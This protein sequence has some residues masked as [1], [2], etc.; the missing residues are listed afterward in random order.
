MTPGWSLP[1]DPS[2]F[3]V[4]IR[5]GAQIEADDGNVRF[6]VDKLVLDTGA[7]FDL[8]APP[9]VWTEHNLKPLGKT[10]METLGKHV[11]CNHAD[12]TLKL[13]PW[14]ARAQ[15]VTPGNARDWLIGYPLLRWFDLLI[16]TV[17]FRQPCLIGPERTLLRDG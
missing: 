17:P 16:R 7:A 12:V 5:T 13:G 6:E 15:L 14:Y 11:Y 10:R 1:L 4:A 3:E 8:I 2:E 9:S